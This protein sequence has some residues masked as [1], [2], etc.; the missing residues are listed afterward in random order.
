MY[1]E[2]FALSASLFFVPLLMFLPAPHRTDSEIARD[3]F[4]VMQNM[5]M[6]FQTFF[7]HT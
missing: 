1:G 2:A 5:T 4:N 7:S 3:D 6:A